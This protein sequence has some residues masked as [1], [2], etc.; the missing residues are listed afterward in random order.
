MVKIVMSLVTILRFL[1]TH[2]FC[3]SRTVNDYVYYKFIVP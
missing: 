1:E 3:H 2:L